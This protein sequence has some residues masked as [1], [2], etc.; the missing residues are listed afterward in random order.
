M[1]QMIDCF[2]EAPQ[3]DLSCINLKSY[4]LANLPI[5]DDL[6]GTRQFEC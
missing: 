3:V 6:E 2:F 1:V 4:K 5:V